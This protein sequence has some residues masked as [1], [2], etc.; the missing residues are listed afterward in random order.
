MDPAKGLMHSSFAT[1]PGVAALLSLAVTTAFSVAE[2]ADW[3]SW[4]GPTQTGVSE[5]CCLIDSWTEDG[6]GTLWRAPFTGRST[7][8]VIDG[9]VCA[10]GRTGA[11]VTRQEIA[12]CFDAGS[13]ERLWEHRFNVF[14]TT[15]PFNRVGWAS[16]VADPQTGHLYVHGVQGLLICYDEAG[17]VIWERSLT[18]EFGRISGYGGRVHTP[19]VVDD[20][21]VFSYLNRSWCDQ[22]VPSHR[23]VAFDK[24][25]GTVVWISTPGGR[26]LDTTYS[27]PVVADIAGRRLLIGGNADGGIYALVAATGEPVWNFSLSKR[28]VNTSVVVSGTKVYATHSEENV[29]TTVM[30][31]VVCID[32]T[33]SGDVTATHELW[34]LDGVQ[35][36]YAS[37]VV[38]GDDLYV[39][40]NSANLH[41]IDASSGRLHW[42]HN[43]GTVG[44]GS[45]VWADDKLYVTEVNGFVKIL[46]PS[47]DSCRELDADRILRTDGGPAEIFAAPAVADGRV[48]ISTEAGLLCLAP[49]Q[50][51]EQKG[52]VPRPQASFGTGKPAR[53]QIVPAEVTMAQ[54]DLAEFSLR[55]FDGAGRRLAG[56][57]LSGQVTWSGDGVGRAVSATSQGNGVLVA[58]VDAIPG[59]GEVSAR[60]GSLTVRSRVRVIEGNDWSEDFDGLEE[61]PGHWLGVGGGKFVIRQLDDGNHVLVKTL[62]KRGLQRSNIFLG[63]PDMSDYVVQVDLMGTRRKRN[64]P[65]MGLIAHRYTLDLMGNHQWLQIRSW[66]SDLRMAKQIP[67]E[68]QTDEWYRMKMAVQVADEKAVVKGKVW[69]RDEQEPREWTLTAED[70]LPNRHGS[71]GIYGYSAAEIYY[72]NLIVTS[73]ES[74][75]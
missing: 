33:G 59:V 32:A 48:Y 63:G 62:A 26:P 60:Y 22:T 23:Y 15:I 42:T 71:P 27:T 39:V 7:P 41:L 9:R 57:D 30:G 29:D 74:A 64:R 65:D 52:M 3:T 19:V 66:A 28:G 67:Y 10:V 54:G 18:E 75:K 17:N 50:P 51:Q 68:W 35:V 49:R 45:P 72:D 8:V 4:R 13:G 55:R 46:E 16:P 6:D 31:R 44:R 2:A 25:N 12:A 58:S 69:K 34:R 53:I 47:A 24:L 43:I 20:L 36:G 5:E 37:P 40:D 38:H 1:S 56:R 14:H 70:P 73:G 21:L 11:D 61:P